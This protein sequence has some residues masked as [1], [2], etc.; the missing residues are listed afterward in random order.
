M[1][2]IKEFLRL[3]ALCIIPSSLVYEE[4]YEGEN[5]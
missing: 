5:Q 4:D 2:K 3:L 1:K